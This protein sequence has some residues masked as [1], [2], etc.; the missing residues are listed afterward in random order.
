MRCTF[1]KRCEHAV[2]VADGLVTRQA[3]AS[4]NI[5]GGTYKALFSSCVHWL[6]GRFAFFYSLSETSARGREFTTEPAQAFDR[7]PV[8]RLLVLAAAMTA[9]LARSNRYL[10]VNRAVGQGEDQGHTADSVDGRAA[11]VECVVDQHCD[12]ADTDPGSHCKA[13][14]RRGLV[15]ELKGRSS[16]NALPGRLGRAAAKSADFVESLRAGA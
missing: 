13:D 7:A 5:A 3:K 14:R 15:L 9:A 12:A 8:V 4:V 2:T 11:Q 16:G 6:S 1:G 10:S